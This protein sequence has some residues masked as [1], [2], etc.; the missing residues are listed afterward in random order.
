MIQDIRSSCAGLREHR[1]AD[2]VEA[3]IK[4]LLA[5]DGGGDGLLE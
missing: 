1:Y 3:G 2:G 4:P 5:R